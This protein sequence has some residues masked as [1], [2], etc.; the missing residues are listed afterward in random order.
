VFVP[1]ST[2]PVKSREEVFDHTQRTEG[3]AAVR[4]GYGHGMCAGRD[5][6]ASETADV[7]RSRHGTHIISKHLER[8]RKGEGE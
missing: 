7:V 8:S 3:V 1:P 4:V 5:R 2:R 6:L